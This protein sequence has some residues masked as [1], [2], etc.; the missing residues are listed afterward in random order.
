MLL[1]RIL[2]TLFK[3]IIKKFHE[4]KK[5]I[6][7]N[8]LPLDFDEIEL[9]AATYERVNQGNLKVTVKDINNNALSYCIVDLSTLKDNQKIKLKLN[10][11]ITINND[12][13]Y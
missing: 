13:R 6:D 4:H 7:I 11:Q 1:C 3:Y 12:R 10:K 9:I 5:K 2:Q 8:R